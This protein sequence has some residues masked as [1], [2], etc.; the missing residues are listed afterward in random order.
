MNKLLILF[1][2]LIFSS[3]LFANNTF[4]IQNFNKERMEL[5]DTHRYLIAKGNLEAF[6]KESSS[7]RGKNDIPSEFLNKNFSALCK[8]IYDGKDYLI[9]NKREGEICLK[10]A[11]LSGYSNAPFILSEISFRKRDYKTSVLWLGFSAGMGYK[12]RNT[13]LYQDLVKFD[14]FDRIYK[15]GL[16]NSLNFPFNNYVNRLE[17]FDNFYISDTI[18]EPRVFNPDNKYFHI[19]KY[20]R[21]FDNIGFVNYQSKNT[22]NASELISLSHVKNKDW[23]SFIKYCNDYIKDT[24]FKQYCL[25]Q[26]YKNTGESKALFRYTMNEYNFYKINKINNEEHFENFYFALG[27]GN[28]QKNKYLKFIINEYFNNIENIKL[29]EKATLAYNK[30]RKYF[31]SIRNLK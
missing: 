29:F 11:T 24:K 6:I 9:K 5:S 18:V 20:L 3:S 16:I 1:G 13:K 10:Y 22:N 17:L 30:G 7:I 21:D 15:V 14:S 8:G 25:K 4:Y 28:E 31:H 26:I 19:Y 12:I 23:I 27:L 2:L